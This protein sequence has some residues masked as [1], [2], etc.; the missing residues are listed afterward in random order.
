MAEPFELLGSIR[1][2]GAIFL[3]PWTPESVG[4]YVAG[5]NHVLPTGG[6]A[7]FSSPLS[8]DDFVKKSS[9][10]GYSFE[11]LEMRRPT[12]CSRSP[13]G[14]PLGARPR[15]LA[16]P[17]RARGRDRRGRRAD[18]GRVTAEWTAYARPRA[19][20]R[21]PRPLRRQGRRAEV[22]LASNENPRNLP[23]EILAQ[24]R[25][26]GCREFPFNRYPDPTATRAARAHRRGERARAENVLVGNGGDELIFDLLLA[27]GG[28]GRTL[29]DMPPTFSMYGDRRRRSTGTEVVRIP[30]LADFSIDEEAVLARVARGRHRHRRRRQPEQPDRRA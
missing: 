29:L 6:T 18:E 13:S 20:A 9:V 25:R 12:P 27:W 28:P 19:R 30:R 1:N 7:R 8:V 14:G 23:G 10:L 26:R 22:M 17:R 11:A 5:P 2:A 16:A 3:G 21:R 4:D 15:R 24:A